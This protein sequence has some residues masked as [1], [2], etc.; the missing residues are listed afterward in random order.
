M[1]LP[2]FVT[3]IRLFTS[4]GVGAFLIGFCPAQMQA[5]TIVFDTLGPG[6]TYDQ[7]NGRFLIDSPGGPLIEQAAQFTAMTSGVLATVD[8]GLTRIRDTSGGPVTIFLYGDANGSP[9]NADQTALLILGG[10]T[11]VFGT[12]NNSLEG[13][14]VLPVPVTKG[15]VYWLVVKPGRPD[16]PGIE[17]VHD[18]WN[19]SL[20]T[21]G[22]AKFSTDD[23]IW[24]P[25]SNNFLPAFRIT[26]VSTPD[27]A[28]TLL[29][30][31]G[32]VAALFVL[33]RVLR[34]ERSS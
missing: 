23:S 5:T 7:F 6:N 18:V 22:L 32:S 20:T 4:L 8:L 1:K 2:K 30:M 17:T 21:T 15:S 26:A 16:M 24:Q 28:D 25:S 3:T 27:S 13:F 31:L 14:E 11:A 12:T 9:D 19:S 33:Q 10:P 29:I 34:N